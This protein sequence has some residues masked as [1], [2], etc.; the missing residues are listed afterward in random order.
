MSSIDRCVVSLERKEGTS[1]ID[2]CEAAFSRLEATESVLGHLEKIGHDRHSFT[3]P[4]EIGPRDAGKRDSG[5]AA[6]SW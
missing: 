5:G 3:V 6:A 4:T 2:R 1:S